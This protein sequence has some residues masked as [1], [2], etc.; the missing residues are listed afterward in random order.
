[1]T[2][3]FTN[4]GRR[5]NVAKPNPAD[6]D[7]GEIARALG[8]TNRYNGHTDVPVSVAVH[9]VLVGRIAEALCRGSGAALCGLLHD[10]HEAYIGDITSPVG[11]VL[12]ARSVALD[13]LKARTQHAIET[14]V[15][16]GIPPFLYEWSRLSVAIADRIALRLEVDLAFRAARDDWPGL[17]DIP[18]LPSGVEIA[19]LRLDRGMT[20]RQATRLF[21]AELGRELEAAGGYV[22]EGMVA[23][24]KRRGGR[25]RG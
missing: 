1:M 17:D 6:V 21:S 13:R 8:A 9:S 5:W 2:F 20:P 18:P 10:A 22:M 25:C 3:A 4:S 7:L 19:D 15:F 24:L 14:A 23:Q 12:G 16:G 11:A